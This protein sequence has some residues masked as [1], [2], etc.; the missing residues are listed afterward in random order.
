MDNDNT[1]SNVCY[2]RLGSEHYQRHLTSKKRLEKTGE[3]AK[4]VFKT[5]TSPIKNPI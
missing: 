3:I 1:N 2:L 4:D 5:K